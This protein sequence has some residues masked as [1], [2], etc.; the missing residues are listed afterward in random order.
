MKHIILTHCIAALG[1]AAFLFLDLPLP[2]LLGPIF[3][4]L[5]AALLGVPMRGMPVVNNLMRTIL[6]VAVGATFTTALVAS[7]AGMWTT[8][9]LVPV[10]VFLIGLIGVPYFQ[11]LW[12]FDFATSY[13]G[14]MPGGL[15]LGRRPEQS[16]WGTRRLPP[17]WAIG[18]DGGGRFG[19]VADRQG[20]GA[21]RGINPWAHDTGR[22]IRTD[23]CFAIPP[24]SR[25]Y[26]GRAVLHWDDGRH[27]I[28][29]RHRRRGP[30]RRRRSPWILRDPF[31]P[32]SRFY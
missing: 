10:L 5:I 2:W 26:L 28:C 21:V 4:C 15:Q 17:A 12:G 20:R 31:D 11:K 24:P 25:G 29:G 3:A 27:E 30:P 19:R 13:Y 32:V 23:G 22:D 8:L 9:M 16:T 18:V 1:V 14:A 7:L 6:G